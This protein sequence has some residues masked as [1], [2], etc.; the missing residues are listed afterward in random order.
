MMKKIL[1][2]T[3]CLLAGTQQSHA[4]MTADHWKVAGSGVATL[5]CIGGTWYC[6][7]RASDLKNYDDLTEEEIKKKIFWYKLL[8]GG[9]ALGAVA[10]G[11]YCGYKVIQLWSGDG[12]DDIKKRE[13]EL[14]EFEVFIKKWLI[15]LL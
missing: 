13:M 11:A 3:I 5:A 1:A 9:C 12:G 6:F 15:A 2:L 8:G 4:K 7:S 10:S 14:A